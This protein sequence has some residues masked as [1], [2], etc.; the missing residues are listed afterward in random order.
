MTPSTN[1][2]VVTSVNPNNYLV[3]TIRGLMC[4]NL[5][6]TLGFISLM[7]SLYIRIIVDLNVSVSP[8]IIHE[9]RPK[10]NRPS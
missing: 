5:P 3:S 9:F 4:I 8:R 10:L 1:L 6:V 2:L 7:S